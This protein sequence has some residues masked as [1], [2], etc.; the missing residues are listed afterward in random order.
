MDR[1]MSGKTIGI[2]HNEPVPSGHAFSEAS[3]DV[4]TQAGEIEQALA[5]LGFNSVRIS[6]TKDLHRFIEAMSE[7][8]P[9]LV[10][11]LCETVDEDPLLAGHPA[12]VLEL[13]G[14]QFTGTTAPGIAMTTDKLVAKRLLEASG[15]P[16][17]HYAVYEGGPLEPPP[18]KFPVII[19]PRWQDASIGI[20]QDSV[21][22]N[23]GDL[24]EKAKSMFESFGPLLIEE[25]IKGRE[26]NISLFGYPVE[27]VLPIAE[28]EFLD[29]P[30][31]LFPIVGYR[32]KWDQSSFEYRHTARR[33]PE[34]PTVLADE[35]ADVAR[36]CFQLF[37]L[38]DYARVDVRVDPGGCIQVLEVNA[39]P[40]LSPDAGF[41]AAAVQ[42]GMRY[43]DMVERFVQF[44][45]LR[46][47]GHV[48]QASRSQG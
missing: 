46:S 25:F 24:Q 34:L 22:E 6:F 26:F 44:M 3:A 9:Q 37:L 16:T 20:D 12:A 23:R 35:M 5:Q 8:R 14:I 7:A 42:S 30:Q 18:L 2:M 43:R 31:E 11:N 28:I 29:Y 38:R 15:I 45:T 47:K 13:M 1:T 32:A 40:C 4:L 10:F 33:F 21:A 36:R 48:Y 27:R 19:K 17:P 39:N 41:A